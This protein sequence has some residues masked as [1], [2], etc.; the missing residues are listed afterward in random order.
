LA[1]RSNRQKRKK[2]QAAHAG[3]AAKAGAT[4]KT[5]REPEPAS[6]PP[7][8]AAKPGM[9]SRSEAKNQAVRDELVPLGEGERPLVVV[10]GSVVSVVLA[11]SQLIAYLAGLEIRGE[12]PPIVSF[13]FFVILLLVMAWGMWNL[14][15]WAVLGYQALLAL[16]ILIVGLALMTAENATAVLVCLAIIVPAGAMFWFMVKALARIQMP[17]RNP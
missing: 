4:P 7:P 3:T 8:A 11:V 17:E 13:A 6:K 1:Q 10:I 12:K 5:E 9:Y 16:V 2:R 14:R 15:Y